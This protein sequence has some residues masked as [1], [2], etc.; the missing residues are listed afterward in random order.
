MNDEDGWADESDFVT[1]IDIASYDEAINFLTK[2]TNE[3]VV[4]WQGPYNGLDVVV[5]EH[6]LKTSADGTTG[7]CDS[8]LVAEAEWI[9]GKLNGIWEGFERIR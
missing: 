1:K 3:Q 8:E 5:Y 6:V 4:K 2:I 7:V 9:D